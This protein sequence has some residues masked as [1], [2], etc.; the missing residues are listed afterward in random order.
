MPLRDECNEK[1]FETMCWICNSASFGNLQWEKVDMRRVFVSIPSYKDPS[2]VATVRQC[3]E[4]A[5]F[6]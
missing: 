6:P 4:Q 2:S 1:T 3:I 5:A